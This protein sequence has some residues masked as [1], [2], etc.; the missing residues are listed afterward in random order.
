M[1]TVA[2]LQPMPIP[3]SRRVTNSCSHAID[4]QT[5]SYNESNVIQQQSEFQ[6]YF[7]R[8]QTRWATE[9][10]RWRMQKCNRGAQRS[11]SEGLNTNSRKMPKQCK[12]RH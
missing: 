2:P 3:R 9:R 10:R 11:C 7:E 12:D 8:M 1:G 5:Y 6:T 4:C